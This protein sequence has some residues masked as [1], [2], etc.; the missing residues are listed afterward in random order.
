MIHHNAL[1]TIMVHKADKATC[2]KHIAEEDGIIYPKHEEARSMAA[3]NKQEYRKKSIP[4][5]QSEHGPPDH[6]DIF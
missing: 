3:K 1:A 2:L 6:A 5:K 4:D